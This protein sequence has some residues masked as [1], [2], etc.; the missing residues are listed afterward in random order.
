MSLETQPERTRLAW[1]RTA[2]SLL[3]VGALFL[4]WAPTAGPLVLAPVVVSAAFAFAISTAQRKRYTTQ[5]LERE[6]ADRAVASIILTTAGV[7]VLA[8]FALIAVATI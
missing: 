3:I 5:T 2:L 6:N 1:G 4:R 8:I 7:A